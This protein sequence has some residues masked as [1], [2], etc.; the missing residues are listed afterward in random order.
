MNDFNS[1]LI[2]RLT[3]QIMSKNIQQVNAIADNESLNLQEKIDALINMAATS[4]VPQSL[5]MP[6]SPLPIATTVPATTSIM[7]ET[8]TPVVDV[9]ASSLINNNL[10]VSYDFE[11]RFKAMSMAMTL[12]K[13]YPRYYN[14]AT[15]DL[16]INIESNLL[17]YE[18]SVNR[19]KGNYDDLYAF[20]HFLIKAEK[21]FVQIDNILKKDIIKILENTQA[22]NEEQEA[23]RLE[24]EQIAADAL[25]QRQNAGFNVDNRA[26]ANISTAFNNPVPSSSAPQYA[27]ATSDSDVYMDTAQRTAEQ[28][29]DQDKDYSIAYSSDKY[30]ALVKNVLLRLIEKAIAKLSKNLHITTVDQLKKLRDYINSNVSN[31]TFQIFLNQEDCVMIKNLSDLASKFFNVRC[32]SDTLETMLEAIRNNMAI[33]QSESNSVQRMVSKIV[34]KNTD[35]NNLVEISMYKNEY[36]NIKNKNVKKLFDLYN[37]RMPINFFNIQKQKRS[38]TETINREIKRPNIVVVSS[39]DEQEENNSSDIDDDNRKEEDE[40]RNQNNKAMSNDIEN[41]NFEKESKR[42]RLEDEELLK[43]KAI[44]FSKDVVNE[45]LQKIIVV[46]DSMKKLYEYCN[47]NSSLK[48]L[49]SVNDYKTLLQTLNLY[50]LDHVDM[51]V[52]FYELMFPLTLYNDNNYSD[53]L[54]HK[55]INYIFV[56]SAYFQNCAKHFNKL[57]NAFNAFGPFKQIDFMVMFIIKF[58]FLCDMRN[59]A[60][61][62]DRVM[63]NKQP[64]IKIHTVLVMRDK[65][66]KLAYNNLQFQN[67]TKKNTFRNTMYLEKLIMLMNANYN[68]L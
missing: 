57:R 12:I 31:E 28:Y 41:F 61:V 13:K 10:I 23:E 3:A 64:N 35:T 9:N 27:Y 24:A 21:S 37:E 18:N 30:N 25:L 45:K 1:L 65:I 4:S 22:I 63:P 29:T 42:R 43:L 58:N 6:L 56:A 8:T 44:E 48:T 32:V 46:T 53:A 55:L 68:I 52:N 66:I 36:N 26:D 54:S 11:I 67:L 47:C 51:N 34:N 33:T 16:I 39:D 20:N 38:A 14:D 19:H 2:T 60:K 59:F 50:N 62:I 17:E 5:P 49:P 15:R 7:F 40:D